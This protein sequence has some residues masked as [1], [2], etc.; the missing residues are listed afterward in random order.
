VL[1]VGVG[2]DRLDSASLGAQLREL[3]REVE[4]P[5]RRKAGA[6]AERRQHKHAF[7]SGCQVGVV[8]IG[9]VAAV[10]EPVVADAIREAAGATRGDGVHELDAAVTVEHDRLGRA[11]VDRR[12]AHPLL[13]PVGTRQPRRDRRPPPRLHGVVG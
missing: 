11:G 9:A 4:P 12:D 1:R 5:V 13:R 10:D 3:G 8:G 7:A 2:E 6:P